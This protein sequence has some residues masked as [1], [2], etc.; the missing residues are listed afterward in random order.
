M[1][2][3]LISRIFGHLF[4]ETHN[5]FKIKSSGNKKIKI[6]VLFKIH[7]TTLLFLGASEARHQCNVLSR[8]GAYNIKIENLKKRPFE[9]SWVDL[10]WWFWL[11]TARICKSCFSCLILLNKFQNIRPL[12]GFILKLFILYL[13]FEICKDLIDRSFISFKKLI[14]LN[15]FLW[16]ISYCFP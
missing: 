16:P 9:H 7:G 3:A 8:W 15:L 13:V 12:K 11:K 14:M 10:F 5:W 1:L 4:F 6:C 2:M